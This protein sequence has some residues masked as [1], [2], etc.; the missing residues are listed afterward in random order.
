MEVEPELDQLDGGEER[1]V[2]GVR[3]RAQ[4]ELIDARFRELVPELLDEPGLADA[5][6]S[7][8]RHEARRTRAGY[9]PLLLEHLALLRAADVVGERPAY[10]QAGLRAARSS[11][12][13]EPHRL[14]DA[15]EL[16]L[17]EGLSPEIALHDTPGGVADCE[18]PRSRLRLEARGDVRRTA[19]G[20][21]SPLRADRSDH[22][23]PCVNPRAYLEQCLG[24][25]RGAGCVRL[26]LAQDVESATNGSPRVILMSAREA[27]VDHDAVAEKLGDVSVVVPDHLAADAMVLGEQVAKVLRIERLRQFGKPDEIAEEHGDLLSALLAVRYRDRLVESLAAGCAEAGGRHVHV[28]T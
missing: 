9:R 14:R 15:L 11:D 17:A 8:H 23:P 1:A 20:E 22:N 25:A 26:N 13:P 10:L 3:R 2:L 21:I 12:T 7:P 6:L 4:D 16:A 28:P 18:C 24:R 27:E 19:L 5:R